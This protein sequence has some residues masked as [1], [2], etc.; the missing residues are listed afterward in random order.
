[1]G[2]A[3]CRELARRGAEV[4]WCLVHTITV[5]EDRS[6]C[7]RFRRQNKCISQLKMFPKADITIMS[8]AVAD[9]TPVSA[10][11]EKIKKNL[12]TRLRLE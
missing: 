4:H 6:T 12:G 3:I 1:M 9:Y 5:D 7:I 11:H 2:V 10:H 8:A